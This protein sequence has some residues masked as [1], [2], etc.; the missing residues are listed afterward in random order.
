MSG[1][2]YAWHATHAEILGFLPFLAD[3]LGRGP[4]VHGC[5]RRQPESDAVDEFSD[6][7]RARRLRAAGASHP[8]RRL[9]RVPQPG[10]AQG[11]PVARDLRRRARRRPQRRGRSA[12]QQCRQPDRPSSHRRDRAA[13]AQGRGARSTRRRLALIRLWIDQG[14]RATPTS[15]PGAA[16]VGGAAGAR[17]AGQS[18]RSAG[19]S[20][21]SHDRSLRR[22]LPRRAPRDGAGRLS[23]TRSSRAASTSTSGDSSQRPR[24]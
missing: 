22:R 11:R 17:P 12:R 24:S 10:Q 20:W 9:L 23:P 2:S 13:D 6:G 1:L 4:L 19:A 18:R 7:A 16:T 5:P 8:R 15:A 21:T 14:A 3:W